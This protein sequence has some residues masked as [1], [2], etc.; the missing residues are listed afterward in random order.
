MRGLSTRSGE[1]HALSAWYKPIDQLGPTDL[2]LMARAPV[3]TD[4][5]LPL[6]SLDDSRMHMAED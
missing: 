5:D 2:E 4:F 6:H 3:G 1:A